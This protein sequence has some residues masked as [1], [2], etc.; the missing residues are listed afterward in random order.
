MSTSMQLHLTT[1]NILMLEFGFW[2][3]NPISG[4]TAVTGLIACCTVG[5]IVC[6][7]PLFGFERGLASDIV[8]KI[9]V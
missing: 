1:Q 5:T 3:P 6:A 8:L 2:V 9:D 4:S 7:T